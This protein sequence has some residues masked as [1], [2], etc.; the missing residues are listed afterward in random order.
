MST[1]RSPDRTVPVA[2]RRG[3]PVLLIEA[4]PAR[5]AERYAT[6]ARV[7]VHRASRTVAR[8]ETADRSGP[9]TYRVHDAA[10][11]LYVDATEQRHHGAV[12]LIV[13]RA[14]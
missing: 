14:P 10:R 12:G 3:D 1:T 13:E 11:L 5:G 8:I 7:W 6:V 2:V 4:A 9:V